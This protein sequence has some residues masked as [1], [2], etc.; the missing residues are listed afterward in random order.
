DLAVGDLPLAEEAL[1]G[2]AVAAGA[3]GVDDDL[4]GDR[5]HG[6]QSWP[7]R[8]RLQPRPA[9]LE[10]GRERRSVVADMA[11][12]RDG[13]IRLEKFSPE[14]KQLVAAAQQ[15]ADE[16][17]HG[18]VQPLHLLARAIERSPGIAAVFKAAGAPPREVA[19]LCDK[20]LTRLPK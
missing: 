8:L 18:E 13:V 11:S 5:A 15:L 19:E 10:A 6:P 7:R 14:A 2:V 20:A 4:G 9:A 1:G 16:R 12:E 3:R 17:Q